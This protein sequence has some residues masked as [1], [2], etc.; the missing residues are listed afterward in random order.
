MRDVGM[1][2]CTVISE[3]INAVGL[4]LP[5]KQGSIQRW[6]DQNGHL[7]GQVDKPKTCQEVPF[8]LQMDNSGVVNLQ[9]SGGEGLA[10]ARVVKLTDGEEDAIF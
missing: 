3:F 10:H 8:A 9:R 7:V 4:R 1:W 6:R 2:L 5:K